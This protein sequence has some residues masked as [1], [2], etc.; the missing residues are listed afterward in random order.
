[1]PQLSTEAETRGRRASAHQSTASITSPATLHV[2]HAPSSLHPTASNGLHRA[3]TQ[4]HTQHQMNI[5]IFSSVG[6][7]QYL[8]SL[9]N[10]PSPP[11]PPRQVTTHTASLPAPPTPSHDTKTPSAGRA[12]ACLRRRVLSLVPW[13]R[14]TG[15]SR[16]DAHV[17][18]PVAVVH[19]P[20]TTVIAPHG[21]SIRDQIPDLPRHLPTTP[22][23]KNRITAPDRPQIMTS[24][25]GSVGSLLAA[26]ANLV[27]EGLRILS[28]TDKRQ[29][30]A[31]EEE[32]VRALEG[33][34]DEAKK[35]FQELAPL[36]N[37]QVYYEN[38][39]K[40]ESIEELKS[41]RV[42]F[43]THIQSLRE[44]SRSGGPINPIWIRETHHLQKELHRAQCR[45][46]RR[47]FAFEKE[48]SAR[49]LGAFLVHRKQRQ[50]ATTSAVRDEEEYF[51]RYRDE[52]LVCNSI[53]SLERFG[54]DDIAF[55]CDFCDGHI[56]WE[57]LESMPS[58]RTAQDVAASPIS[59]VSP[60]TNNPHWQ[61]TGF[62]VSGHV[63]KQIVFAPVAIANHTAPQHR[64][65]EAGLLCPFCEEESALP[66]D[67]HD[68]EDAYRPEIGYE[69]MTTFREHLEW[70]HTATQQPPSIP[71]ATA[72]AQDKCQI[73]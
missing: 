31:D 41:L 47:I 37:G 29:W 20:A 35:D 11:S 43:N 54:D 27:V 17:R 24:S 58:I 4:P 33:V 56:V 36:V 2:G 32:Q 38:D 57:D 25:S 44:W 13:S 73:M 61:A 63:E 26:I 39:R 51:Q 46:A 66:Q 5:G 65:W 68:D 70:Y 19:G 14:P 16:V 18:S 34:L 42:R 28:L 21:A 64:D 71:D 59:P 3:A 40:H 22:A 48:S 8:V 72:S 69:D 67:E 30:G 50:W 9:A 52:L 1:M 53:G 60:T 6:A 55:V 7:T 49:C 10:P 45:V 12:H 23:A 15:A 62:T